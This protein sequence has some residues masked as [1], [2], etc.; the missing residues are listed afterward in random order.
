M[1][2]FLGILKWTFVSLVVILTF[3]YVFQSPILQKLEPLADKLSPLIS[4]V[5]KKVPQ[6]TQNILNEAKISAPVAESEFAQTAQYPSIECAS[7]E[8][9]PFTSEMF[10]LTNQER[11]QNG[12]K[13]LGWSPK[14]CES[15]KLKAQDMINNNYFE[16]VSP[17]GVAPWYWIK[18]VGYTYT[19]VG[20]NLALNYYTAP[21]ANKALMESKGHRENILNENFTQ[22]GVAYLRG[23]I[24]GQDAFVV[25]QHFGSP[26]PQQVT[27]KYTCE[28]EKAEDKIAEFKKTKKKIEKYIEEAENVKDDLKDAGQSTKEVNEYINDMEDKLKEVN[29][30]IKELEDYLAKC[31]Q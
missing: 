26:A 14:L 28:K 20:E 6:A 23:K 1:N 2:R 17:S 19:F 30:Y 18:K 8:N 12:K 29:G 5:Y 4:K 15:A 11:Q 7:P 24:D 31:E 22:M 21:S 27:L 13:T 16:H 9:T 3:L 25:V 10:K